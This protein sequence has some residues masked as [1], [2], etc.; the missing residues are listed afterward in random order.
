MVFQFGELLPE[1]SARENVALAALLAGVAHTTAYDRAEALLAH[2]GV[3]E[4]G[5]PTAY[6]SGGERQRVAV[7]RAL[8]TDPPLILADEPTG[9][10]DQENRDAVADILFDLPKRDGRAL[11][12]VTHDQAVARRADRW[13][14]L[15]AG[16]LAGASG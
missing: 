10:L 15:I 9:A 7:A 16:R 1:L 4:G 3:P 5:T 12:V 11:L 14:D 2:L 8:I 13:L 6:L